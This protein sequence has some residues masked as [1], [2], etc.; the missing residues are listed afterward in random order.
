MASNDNRR[1]VLQAQSELDSL[2]HGAPFTL[3]LTNEGNGETLSSDAFRVRKGDTLHIEAT[4]ESGLLYGAYFLLR[5]QAI[6]DGCLCQTFG[7]VEVIEQQPAFEIRLLAEPDGLARIYRRGRLE[8]Y[9]RKNASVGINGIVLT[10]G[11]NDKGS[12]PLTSNEEKAIE[13]TLSRFAIRIYRHGSQV[14]RV[15][16]LPGDERQQRYLLYL[17]DGWQQ[18]IKAS[19]A[20]DNK[21][22]GWMTTSNVTLPEE[23]G[24]SGH[25]FAE[26]NWYAFGR[27][28]WNPS[29]TTHQI[30]Y[31][32]LAQNFHE[33]PLFIR[34]MIEVML[35]SPMAGAEEVKRMID[36]WEQMSRYVDSERYRRV[37][38]ALADQLLQLL[39]QQNTDKK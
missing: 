25:P 39:I 21:P 35:E 8:D 1:I 15:Q 24:W 19:M 5:S 30:A 27:L 6:G 17:A 38:K 34:P 18:Q 29:I 3:T 11:W 20:A 23:G 22:S 7:A 28:T 12:A 33:S 32:W 4:S 14:Q 37:E 13:E 36:T 9:A 26:S 2:W 16:T 31:E 10:N